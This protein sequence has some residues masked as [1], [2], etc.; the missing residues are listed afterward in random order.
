MGMREEGPRIAPPRRGGGATIAPVMAALD[1]AQALKKLAALGTARTRRVLVRRGVTG[2]MFG[3]GLADLGKLARELR[4]RH[5]LAL[6][7][8]ESGNHDAR[9]LATMIADP[10]RLGARELGRWVATLDNHVLTDAFAKLAASSPA[11]QGEALK[12]LAGHG[13]WVTTAGW[14]TLCWSLVA[15][16]AIDPSGSRRH[17]RMLEKR[18]AR[19]ARPA[20]R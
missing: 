1:A 5:E 17:L 8:W 13:E 7:L 6:E 18:T 9:L 11:G 16:R 15:D 14:S 10:R 3:V 12:W 4:G 19:K 20:R 2:A